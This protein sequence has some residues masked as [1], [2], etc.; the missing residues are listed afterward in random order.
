LT[1]DP[2]QGYVKVEFVTPMPPSILEVETYAS[3]E[4]SM[5]NYY[6]F[7]QEILSLPPME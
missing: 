2:D 4:S 7:A 1:E 3:N 5:S 6:M